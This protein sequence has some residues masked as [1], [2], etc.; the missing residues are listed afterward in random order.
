MNIVLLYESDNSVDIA[1]II[2][3]NDLQW[4]WDG[5]SASILALLDFSAGFGIFDYGILLHWLQSLGI[6]K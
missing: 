5:G 1:L 6:F 3:K 2:L 4:D